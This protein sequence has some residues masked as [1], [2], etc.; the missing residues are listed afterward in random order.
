MAYR[1]IRMSRSISPLSDIWSLVQLLWLFIRLS[2]DA[3]IAATPK[4]G[5]LAMIASLVCSVRV[6]KY[7]VWGCRWD[8]HRGLRAGLAKFG[9]RVACWAATDVIAVSCGIRSLL[10]SNGITRRAVR[11]IG[12]GGSKG[13]DVSRFRYRARGQGTGNQHVIGFAGRLARDKGLEFLLP[14][15]RMVRETLPAATLRLAGGPDAADPENAKSMSA[16]RACPGVTFV[17][18]VADMPGFLPEIDVLC[19]PSL[20]EGLPNAVIEAAACGV[21]TVA[22]SVTGLADAIHHGSTGFL[23]EYGDVAELSKRVTDLLIHTELRESMGLRAR[24]FV[25]RE[26]SSNRVQRLQLDDILG[27]ITNTG[28]QPRI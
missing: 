19:F 26:L 5:M 20:R 21:P 10:R 27:A 18:E 14:M 17:G 16:L 22:W 28:L 15:L 24:E 11:V 23:V 8:G 1:F 9:D 6:R 13:V 4:A 3:V 25:E 7:H 2:P 12:S